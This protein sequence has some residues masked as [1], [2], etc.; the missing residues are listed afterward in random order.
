[1]NTTVSERLAQA[2]KVLGLSLREFAAP[3]GVHL[4]AVRYW[5]SGQ[6][7]KFSKS[8]ALAIEQAFNVSAEWL[9]E[10]KGEMMTPEDEERPPDSPE[11]P[12]VRIKHVCL[13]PRQANATGAMEPSPGMAK[14]IAFPVNWLQEKIGV[15]QKKLCLVTVEGDAMLPTLAPGDMVMIDTT[16]SEAEFKEGIWAFQL[17]KSSYIKRLQQVG[18]TRYR[19]VS[20]N[21]Q[22]PPVEFDSAEANFQGRVVWYSKFI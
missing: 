21:Q 5:E 3:L 11:P 15:H 17:Q 9:L 10:G 22:Y 20:D 14:F 8:H 7:K 4:T 16:A 1:M 6:I 13:Y 2:R 19:A 18:E 12:M